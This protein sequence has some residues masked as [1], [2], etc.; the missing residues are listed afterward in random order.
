MSKGN[1]E[2]KVF[3][4]DQHDFLSIYFLQGEVGIAMFDSNCEKSHDWA[5][6]EPT[7]WREYNSFHA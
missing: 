7:D 4:V 3:S 6:K 5:G 2:K 1:I